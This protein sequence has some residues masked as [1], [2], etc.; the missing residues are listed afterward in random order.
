[1][2]C[3]RSP[4][5]TQIQKEFHTLSILKFRYTGLALVALLLCMTLLACGDN[6][7]AVPAT[8]SATK[9][10]SLGGTTSA[11]ILNTPAGS[12]ATTAAAGTTAAAATTSGGA[13]SVA[14][15]TAAGAT[16][17]AVTPGAG[18]TAIP[19]TT[20]ASGGSSTTPGTGG[21]AVSANPCLDTVAASATPVANAPKPTTTVTD[22]ATL[23]N[24]S[25]SG[26][27][28]L[29]AADATS[30]GVIANLADA[31]FAS[32][33]GNFTPDKVSFADTAD[34]FDKVDAFLRQTLESNGWVQFRVESD[35]TNKQSLLVYQKG[36]S[37]VVAS[38]ESIG[39]VTGYP[40]EFQTTIK[41]GDTLI[42]IASGK[43]GQVVA[44]TPF[45]IPGSPTPA[46]GAGQNAFATIEMEKGG[47][48]VIQLCPNLAPKTV[49]NFEKLAMSNFYNG[50]T[51]HRVEKSPTPFVVQGGDPKG[52]GT[53]GPGYSI[54][55]EFT[56]LKKHMRGTVA[57][58]HSSAPNSAGSQF[59][60]CLADA[61]H[62]DGGY[63]IF[64]QVVEGMDVVDNIAIGD[65]MK[66]VTITVK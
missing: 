34:S 61:P 53:G 23:P 46:V 48:I 8:S 42:L 21:T 32:I 40:A 29:T 43:V 16:T 24:L 31:Q 39:D 28:D 51:F 17:A 49:E 22:L 4:G 25:Y 35:P 18:T 30:Q 52:D 38:L 19:A 14:G 15:T 13:S 64:G 5:I 20:A 26:Q 66:S 47:K 27:K 41:Q 33:F 59:Y 45:A 12:G 6:P 62:L 63:A 58:A 54:P 50:L 11:P 56:T 57:M 60:I 7:T 3:H 2:I 44:A 65:K 37:K 9:T 55:D 1:L 10:V 36:G